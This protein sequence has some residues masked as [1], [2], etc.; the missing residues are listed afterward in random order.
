[1][2]LVLL[3]LLLL[4]CGAAAAALP[5]RWRAASFGSLGALMASLLAAAG[6]FY[7]LI[8]GLKAEIVFAWPLPLGACRIGVDP[9]SAFFV[10][11]IGV[12]AAPAALYG[13]KYLAGQG[14]KAA[15]SWCW[16]NLLVAAMLLVVLARDGF[17][18]LIA[19][20][21][22]SLA[23]FFLVMYDS[24]KEGVARAGW[25]YLVATHLGTAFLLVMFLLLGRGDTSFAHFS[26]T[27][28]WA[29]V[30]FAAALIGFGTKA[31]L[32]P[33]HIWLPEAHPVAPSHVSALM[34]GAMIKTGIYGLLRVLTFLGP[35][36]PWWGWVLL[37]IG[38]VSGLLGVLSALAQHNLKRLLAYSSVENVG[39]VAMGL[40]LGLLCL[41][42]DMPAV[43]ALGFCGALLHALNHAIFKGLLFLGAGSVL[44]ATGTGE[45]DRM[46]GLI[47][48]MPVTGATFMVGAAAISGL[49]PL[50]GFVSEFLVYAAGFAA[51]MSTGGPV[52][53]GL[54]VVAGLAL[55]GGLAA[56][57]FVKAFG[58]VFLG[59]PRGPE[60]QKAHEAPPAMQAA[61]VTLALL[62]VA[63]G[64]SAPAMI[65]IIL[66]VTAQ[67]VPDIY[68]VIPAVL[69]GLLGWITPC[70]IFIIVC[71]LL[72]L[73]LRGRLLGRRRV[74]QGET[75]GCGYTR[76]SPRVQYTASSFS[77]PIEGMF[78]SVLR[79][80][81]NLETPHGFFPVQ[82]R[83]ATQTAELFMRAVYEPALRAILGL[84][85]LFRA[86]QQG[87]THLYILYIVVTLLLL[88]I[89]NLG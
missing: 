50:N 64:L 24:E 3:P 51:V 89:W 36:Q 70:A 58:I 47:K 38:L 81:Q 53:S 83:L 42:A 28:A 65:Q 77:Q 60:A 4:L 40:G 49:P 86:V 88:L 55:I 41:H 14:A 34:S 2:A 15:L 46:G 5:G 80:R 76:S 21:A 22:M 13:R 17:L 44:H 48:R 12:V 72:L 7:A 82:A 57:C 11:L 67:L 8:S 56:A 1:M 37:G 84:A 32:V 18:F 35:P 69:I 63:I 19:W 39:I 45:L 20:E 73:W 68:P 31:G 75:W 52:W 61:M 54:A 30:I 27:G 33:L 74:K 29:G 25:I 16:Y 78:A 59:T 43:A 62:C 87:R 71:A 66:P 6:G 10:L 85:A 79:P 9:L 23:S 26:A